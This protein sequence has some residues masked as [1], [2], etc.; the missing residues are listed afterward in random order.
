[1]ARKPKQQ[2]LNLGAAGKKQTR[3]RKAGRKA[4]AQMTGRIP[5]IRGR[6]R[7]RAG[8]PAGTARSRATRAGSVLGR[9]AGHM[10]G[11]FAN[12]AHAAYRTTRPKRAGPSLGRQLAGSKGGRYAAAG[13][14]AGVAGAA[15]YGLVKAR[16]G[17]SSQTTQVVIAVPA[18]GPQG[19][20]RR[21]VLRRRRGPRRD[22]Y[23]RFR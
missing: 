1:V 20:R 17:R 8:H 13:V 5:P 4:R 11:G 18:P 14:G 7:S 23:G 9:Q 16:I 19:R 22:R 12:T 6:K 3:A 10:A 2:K 21:G 15:G